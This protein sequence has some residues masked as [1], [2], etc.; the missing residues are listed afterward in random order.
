MQRVA[1]HTRLRPGAEEVYE[2]EHAVI[3]ADLEAEMREY[4]VHSWRIWRAGL[5]LFHLVEVDDYAELQRRLGGS[6]ANQAWQRQMN[7]LLDADF[8]PGAGGLGLVWEMT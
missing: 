3:P 4:G 1:L 7:R 5:D 8:D 6:A 2:A